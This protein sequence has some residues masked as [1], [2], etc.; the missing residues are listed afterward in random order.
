[1]RCTIFYLDTHYYDEPTYCMLFDGEIVAMNTS[2]DAAQRSLSFVAVDMVAILTQF[3]PY[4]VQ[5]T[6][7]IV[8]SQLDTTRATVSVATTPFPRSTILF[9]NQLANPGQ[10]VVRPFD[11]AMNIVQVLYGVGTET[12]DR[13][14]VIAHFF[15]KWADMTQFAFRFSPSDKI[16][17][18]AQGA[19]KAKVFPIL[20]AS[21]DE[22][23]LTAIQS[24]ADRIASSGSYYQMLQS[25]FRHMYV[26]LLM[27]LAPPANTINA[28]TFE[29][30]GDPSFVNELNT[31]A[32][33]F[34]GSIP[35]DGAEGQTGASPALFANRT[36]VGETS[37]SQ[38][39]KRIG[40][41][42]YL[43]RPRVL[44]GLTPRFNV[45]WT[46]QIVSESYNENYAR[47]P[48]RTYLGNTAPIRAV[49]QGRASKSSQKFINFAM[50][51]AWPEEADRL[52][53][54]KRKGASVS[55]DNFLVYPEEFFKGPVYN[56]VM[57]E[58]WYTYIASSK[59]T[60]NTERVEENRR[61]LRI[62]AKM[63]HFRKR[64]EQRNGSVAMPFNPY[65]VPGFPITIIDT[66]VLNMHVTADCLSINHNLTVSSQT[67]SVSY[68]FAQTLDEM[69]GRLAQAQVDSSEEQD[70]V[71]VAPFHPIRELRER[72]QR[73]EDSTAYYKQTFYQESE[74]VE[75]VF[76]YRDVMSTTGPDAEGP[77]LMD[78]RAIPDDATGYVP[79]LSVRTKYAAQNS[80]FDAAMKYCS[81]PVCTLEQYIDFNVLH[82]VREQPREC[83]HP[84]EGKRAL[85]YVK[86]LDLKQ[87]PG[88]DPGR[89][90]NGD[91]CGPANADTRKNWESRLLAYRKEVYY[92]QSPNQA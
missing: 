4:F 50:T 26:D 56:N 5:N 75:T 82:G 47:Q 84:V 24:K 76:D 64:G 73:L 42:Q 78:S 71:I 38:S 13:S 10:K 57:T 90:T 74:Y 36:I 68:S 1:M 66:D 60:N 17:K 27:N 40:I 16:S 85:Y 41:G 52:L 87:G 28:L 62:Y 25:V 37:A 34:A 54:E 44:Y 23:V 61:T 11:I 31:T 67:T 65:V 6:S 69:L 19:E 3:V 14:T 32:T 43:V 88:V 35:V 8:N 22:S 7:N 59:N 9:N 51:V 39:L 81:R 2:R 91:C 80:N 46:S 70:D 79:T 12:D 29:T 21:Q 49:N 45:V 55:V 63:E 86:I 58:D 83:N 20:R 89:K 30:V 72:F 92:K 48:T 53:Q 18:I 77:M 15:S 33:Q